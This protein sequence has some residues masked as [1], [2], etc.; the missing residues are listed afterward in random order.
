M[1]RRYRIPVIVLAAAVVIVFALLPPGTQTTAP[2]PASTVRG[3]FHIHSSRSD[4][5]G[6][7]EVIAAAA[8]RAGLQFIILT[9][10]GD[11]TR[12]PD[13]PAYRSGVLTID[14][15]ELNTTAG[16]YAAIG[17]AASFGPIAS[18]D[19]S[20]MVAPMPCSPRSERPSRCAASSGSRIAL[21]QR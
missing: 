20:S 13:A 7:V 3:A 9:D 16:H 14:G 11:A 5:S 12:T 6:D 21:F 10:H 4:G 8:A 19:G 2:P 17:L 15:V 1:P 18:M